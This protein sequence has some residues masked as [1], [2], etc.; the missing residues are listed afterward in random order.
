MTSREIVSG[1]VA[2]VVLAA[3]SLL[4]APG[5]ERVAQ[6]NAVAPGGSDAA[7]G[8]K[9]SVSCDPEAAR[10]GRALLEWEP[11]QEPGSEQEV[12]VTIFREGFD[13]GDFVSSKAL[14][15]DQTSL[16]FDQVAGQALHRWRVVTRHGTDLVPSD[17]ARFTGPICVYD[18]AEREDQIPPIP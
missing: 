16:L 4:L 12:Q 15:P 1:R 14:P 11:A 18:A 9:A 8:L 7:S 6:R 2:F 10:K 13:T 5:C 17:T 3:V